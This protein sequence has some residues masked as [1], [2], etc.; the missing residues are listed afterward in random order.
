MRLL[1]LLLCAIF[2]LTVT[3][4]HAAPVGNPAKPAML[5]KGLLT[6]DTETE[7]AF[8][9]DPEIDLVFDRRLDDQAADTE[10]T[11]YGSKAGFLLWDKAYIYGIAGLAD[12]EQKF[13][14]NGNSVAWDTDYGLAWGGGATL[15]VFEKPVE[16]R[17]K[18]MLRIGID[19]RYRHSELDVD[20]VILN[21]ASFT[22]SAGSS[23]SSAG[24]DYN[25]WQGAIGVSVQFE[26]LIPY[27]GVKYSEADGEA[28]ATFTTTEYKEDI[29]ADDNIGVFFGSDFVVSDSM[30]L[31]V[32]GRLIDETAFSG[33]GTIRF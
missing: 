10:Y 11:F 19:G 13:T 12:S 25:E 9:I 26:N 31:Y 24:F 7:F 23:L 16:I 22:P 4:A 17:E 18:A 20:N 27:A 6:N 33:G 21:G 2:L 3:A 29:G 15:I 30:S 1:S 5:K 8:V 14:I 28:K 32:E